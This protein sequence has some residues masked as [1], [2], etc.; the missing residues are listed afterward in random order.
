MAFL[1]VFFAIPELGPQPTNIVFAW[2]VENKGD[3]QKGKRGA[4]SAEVLRPPKNDQ[5]GV[6]SKKNRDE[7]PISVF[8][9]SS[10][11]SPRAT[12]QTI[13]LNG[14]TSRQDVGPALVSGAFFFVCVV[15]IQEFAT[16]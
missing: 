3:P 4:N 1:L 13:R 14:M 7:P 10:P 12:K 15:L 11:P 16:V 5:K 8:R 6:H 2:L 9:G